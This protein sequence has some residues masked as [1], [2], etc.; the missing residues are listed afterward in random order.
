MAEGWERGAVVDFEQDAAC[1]LDSDAGHRGQDRQEGAQQA[2]PHRVHGQRHPL[3]GRRDDGERGLGTLCRP[4]EDLPGGICDLGFVDGAAGDNLAVVAVASKAK[5]IS[6][7][8]RIG[9][10]WVATMTWQRLAT[11]ARCRTT[12]SY[13]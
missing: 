9:M 10:L 8:S 11:S 5:I 6:A 12:W 2:S 3:S 4:F 13:M 7:S 1:G